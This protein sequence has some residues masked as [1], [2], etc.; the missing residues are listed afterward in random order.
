MML[1]QLYQ[2]NKYLA[3][4]ESINRDTLWPC[5]PNALFL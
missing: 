4:H 2:H 5:I 1:L 3:I